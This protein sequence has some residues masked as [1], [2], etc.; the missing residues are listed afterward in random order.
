MAIGAPA[1]PAAL[2]RFLLERERA[3]GVVTTD[4]GEHMVWFE[5]QGQPTAV[6]FLP[7]PHQH[8]TLAHLSFR[9]AGR[10]GE[11][12]ALVRVPRSWHERFGAELVAHYSTM[13]EF[14]VERPPTDLDAAFDLACEHDA[15]A[16]CTLVLPGVSLRQHARSLLGRTTWFLHE[17]P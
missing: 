3:D 15:I 12:A 10:S 5:P 8:E 17:R 13:L 11:P 6:V 2:E 9:G 1:T 16:P 14:V 7:T 4:D